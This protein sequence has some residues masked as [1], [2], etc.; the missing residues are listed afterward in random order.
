[1][2]R[3]A[4][5]DG[6]SA[7]HRGAAPGHSHECECG[8]QKC[9]RYIF[10]R[11]S[12]KCSDV[13]SVNARIEIVVVLSVQFG[14]TLASQT[15]KLGTSCACPKRFVTNR[16]GSFPMR[17]VPVSCRLVPGMSGSGAEPR[18]SAPL[19]RSSCSQECLPCSHINRE[20]LSHSKCSLAAGMPYAS[21]TSGSIST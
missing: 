14:N 15:Y 16:L 12:S 3:K 6:A 11:L 2:P 20:F 4:R 9:L 10:L 5:A 1:M 8:T 7:P 21:L 13:R 17:R 18:Y 19:A